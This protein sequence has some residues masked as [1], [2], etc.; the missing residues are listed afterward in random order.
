MR[1]IRI[2][3]ASNNPCVCVYV[4]VSTVEALNQSQSHS[5]LS[6]LLRCF[7]T[8]TIIIAAPLKSV[9]STTSQWISDHPQ[10]LFFP[11]AVLTYIYNNVDDL[12]QAWAFLNFIK[13][14]FFWWLQLVLDNS[15]PETEPQIATISMTPFECGST[16]SFHAFRSFACSVRDS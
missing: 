6:H 4:P 7:P 3:R 15:M 16:A 2:C 11:V 1:W 5:P 12:C 13:L 10:S 8:R 14:C 9:S